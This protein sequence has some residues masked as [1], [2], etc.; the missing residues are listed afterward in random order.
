MAENYRFFDS[1]SYTE[2]NFA[3][4]MKKIMRG[5]GVLEGVLNELEVIQNTP[6]AMNVL[7]KT[8]EAWAQGVWYQ[9]TA[10]QTMTIEAADASWN[11]IDR[12]VLR[13]SWSGNSFTANVLKGTK[14][15]SPTAPALTQSAST[16]EISLAQIAVAAAAT[17]ILTADITDERGTS[18]CG[19]ASSRFGPHYILANG[20]LSGNGQLARGYG[21]PTAYKDLATKGYVDTLFGSTGVLSTGMIVAWSGAI[22][23]VPSGFVFCNGAS[24]TPDLRGRMIVGAVADS[25]DP[26]W[27]V[28]DTGGAYDVAIAQANLPNVTLNS[29]LVK[30]LA[31]ADS[32]V[33]V[34][35][36]SSSSK[37]AITTSA[38]G[39]GTKL[40]IM[41][42]YYVLAYIMK[43]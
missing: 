10:Q 34:S 32:G 23:A 26:S 15:A 40:V 38:L 19:W 20:D 24:S 36:G 16:W 12:I 8:G 14:A 13:V 17:S 37:T 35:S 5:D 39:S 41:N 33:Y 11:R 21:T 27:N 18:Y 3:E 30:D 25:G 42:P 7:L 6:A 31:G 29:G 1:A 28:D 2:A 9:N 43:T 22:S 4:F